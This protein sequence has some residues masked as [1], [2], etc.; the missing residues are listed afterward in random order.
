MSDKR[1]PT[2]SIIFATMVGTK[3]R[4]YRIGAA[5]KTQQGNY[6]V[7]MHSHPTCEGLIYLK[8]TDNNKKIPT[9]L[10][11]KMVHWEPTEDNHDAVYKISS[12]YMPA[13]SKNPNPF[14]NNH[15]FIAK[16]S[17]KEV[18][19]LVMCCSTTPYASKDVKLFFFPINKKTSIQEEATIQ[20]TSQ[21]ADNEGNDDWEEQRPGFTAP[22]DNSKKDDSNMF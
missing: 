1:Q 13:G 16:P 17:D 5:W 6:I 22:G 11:S 9:E 4:T 10:L 20:E 14:F 19:F 12:S 7:N 18:D 21:P 8:K 3:V 2:Y 15:G